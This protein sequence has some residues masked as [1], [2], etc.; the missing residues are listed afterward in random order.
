MRISALD[1]KIVLLKD[2]GIALFYKKTA[3][4]SPD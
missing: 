2:L 4:F 3:F 1:S